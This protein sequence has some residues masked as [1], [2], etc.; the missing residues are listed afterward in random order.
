MRLKELTRENSQLIRKWRNED[1]AGFRTAYPLTVEMQD[2][3]YNKAICNRNSS[4]RYWAITAYE[5]IQPS[6]IGMVGL[7][8]IQQENGLAEISLI[9][10]PD[11][12]G[13]GCGEEA[14]SLVLDQAFN[15][16]GLK[17][18]FG[19]CYQCSEAIPF[20]QKICDKYKAYTTT[21]PN[22][23]YWDGNYYNSLYFSVSKDGFDSA[24]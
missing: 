19:E 11:Y 21:L 24:I 7:T 9:I 14:V 12:R 8:D 22:R 18:V 20:W 13:K 3:F 23:K 6:F 17:T 1:L 16:L 10:H 4:H 5:L 15:Y 2:D